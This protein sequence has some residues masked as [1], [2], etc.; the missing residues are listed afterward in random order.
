MAAEGGVAEDILLVLAVYEEEEAVTVRARSCKTWARAAEDDPRRHGCVCVEADPFAD[1]CHE[2]AV[3]TGIP[4]ECM[5]FPWNEWDSCG[6]H[7]ILAE[8][9]EFLRNALWCH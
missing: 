2:L 1:D 6:M 8:C 5:E 4:V 7:E 9:V 3:H